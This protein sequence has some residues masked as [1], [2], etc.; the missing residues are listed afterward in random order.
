M[1]K[2]LIQIHRFLLCQSFYPL[3]LSSLLA[4]TIYSGRLIRAEFALTYFNL[5]WN[6]F[7]AWVPY[8]FAFLA[9][10]LDRWF[11]RA[12]WLLLVPGFLWLI[13]FPNAAY[14]ITDFTHLE[15]RP[16]VPL[17]YDILM[18]VTF[19][20]TGVFLAV[21]SLHTMQDLVRKY[22]GGVV[23]WVFVA[24]ALGLNGLGIYLGRFDRW[25]SWELFTYPEQIVAD[26]VQRVANPL[27][28]LRFIG[29]TGILTAF[30]L[31]CYLMFTTRCQAD[32]IQSDR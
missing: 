32:K 18:L 26:V 16:Y 6:L 25:N 5:I 30:L 1:R 14:I 12:W 29:F 3:V 20:W 19:A 8:G 15:P 17:W 4:V 2:W 31:I 24:I 22:L 23:S 11:P 21:A 13:F 10:L 27:E 7:L 28:N 9:A